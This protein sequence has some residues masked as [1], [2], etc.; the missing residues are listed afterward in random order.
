MGPSG[1][2]ADG[3]RQGVGALVR[4][5]TRL[6][7]AAFCLL[8]VNS[9]YILALPSATVFY[10]ANVALHLVLGLAFLALAAVMLKRYPRECGAFLAAGLP[11][12]FLAVRGNTLA[13][14]WVLW[15]HIALAA[16]AVLLIGLRLFQTPAAR[17]W[18]AGFAVSAALLVAL[19]AGC[20]DLPLRR[21][22]TPTT[23]S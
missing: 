6:R 21:I 12:L 4:P 17:A 22:P 19:P 2:K 9:A 13:H 14:R 1:G 5:T 10:M 18:K 8:L 20:M 11:A 7:A 3:P 16:L 15:L 23:A